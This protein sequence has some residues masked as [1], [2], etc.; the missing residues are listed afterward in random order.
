LR[1]GT[2]WY[3]ARWDG[4]ADWRFQDASGAFVANQAAAAPLLGGARLDG[5][6][7][8]FPW[9]GGTALVT[10]QGLFSNLDVHLWWSPDPEGPYQDLGAVAEIPDGTDV[11][12]PFRYLG[13][14][15]P[16]ADGRLLLAWNV[17]SFDWSALDLVGR[18]ELIR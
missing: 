7:Q 6:P 10:T 3:L 4:A 16:T 9:L 1:P 13:A 12:S 5:M 15:L 2:Q 11:P 8:V 14:T 17:N 18:A